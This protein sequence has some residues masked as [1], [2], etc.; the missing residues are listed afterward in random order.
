[1]PPH[2]PTVLVVEDEAILSLAIRDELMLDGFA[3]VGPFVSP[4]GAQEWLVGARP[5]C[6]VLDFPT[7]NDDA[8][9]ALAEDLI[10]RGVPVIVVSAFQRETSPVQVSAALWLKKPAT[11]KALTS[12]I[13]SACAPSAGE[14]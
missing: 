7:S 4:R 9:A 1:M 3:V 5:D 8:A 12:A 6:A 13:R 10:R 2:H 11:R 14:R